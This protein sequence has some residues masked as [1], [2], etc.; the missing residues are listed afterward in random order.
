MILILGA[1]GFIGQAF[2]TE[3]RRRGE[4]FIL[5]T[6]QALDYTCFELL[7]DYVRRMRP[8]FIINAAGFTG[9]ANGEIAD[10][11][12]QEALFANTFLPQKIARVCMM[13]NTPWAHISSGDIYSGAKLREDGRMK[14]VRDLAQSEIQQRYAVHPEKFLGFSEWDEPNFTFR[15]PPCTFYSGTKALAEE[16]I[17]N[18]DQTYI[19]RPALPFGEKDETRNL[20]SKIHRSVSIPNGIHSVS[21]VGDFV[22]ACLDLWE[23][24]TPFGIYNV[25][26]PGIV[27]TQQMVELMQRTGQVRDFN[28]E[29]DSEFDVLETKKLPS[30]VLDISKLMAAGVRIRPAETALESALRKWTAPAMSMELAGFGASIR[31]F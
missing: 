9:N 10:A 18:F 2:A 8:E 24:R 28:F 16:A 27:T 13:T 14:V 23:W 29:S 20:L 4:H 25:A 7:F 15:A 17:R 5:L 3:L 22:R 31:N 21:H 1:T 6:R 26:N 12:H 30:Y 19:W 11:D